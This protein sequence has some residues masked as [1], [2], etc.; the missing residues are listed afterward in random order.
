MNCIFESANRMLEM[1]DNLLVIGKAERL[2]FQSN[3]VQ[4]ILVIFPVLD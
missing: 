2:K 3:P 1:V 4:K